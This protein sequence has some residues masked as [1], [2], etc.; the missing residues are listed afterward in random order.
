MEQATISPVIVDPID[1][2]GLTHNP[3]PKNMCNKSVCFF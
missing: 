1:L 2:F 3:N